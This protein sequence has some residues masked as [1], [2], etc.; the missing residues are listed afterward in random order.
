MRI[1]NQSE[2]PIEHRKSPKETFGVLR[3]HVSL[4]L[5]GVKDVG[6]WGGGH[7]F[8]VELATL[9]P[10]KRGYPYHSHAAQTEYYIVVRGTGQVM[11]GSGTSTRIK[12]GDHFIF[13]PGEAHQI[14]NDTDAELTYLV[15]ADHHRAD[16]TTYP[17]TGKRMIKPEYRCGRL[18]EA[19][20]YEN[21]E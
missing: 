5:G 6:P 7:P 9:P 1:I 16:V 8:D 15:I 20:Y 14:L 18:V 13:L 12:E 2:V 17:K 21:E 3:R 19:D 10:G 4:S 11:D